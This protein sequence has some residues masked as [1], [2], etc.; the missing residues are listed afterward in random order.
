M[1]PYCAGKACNLGIHLPHF[2]SFDD[3]AIGNE[4]LAKELAPT[5]ARVGP[6]ASSLVPTPTLVGQRSLGDH[7]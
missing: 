5:K 6:R 7:Y 3:N 2:V 4:K 1:G